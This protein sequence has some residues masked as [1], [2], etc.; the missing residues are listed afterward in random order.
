[1][2]QLLQGSEPAGGKLKKQEKV[3][4]GLQV[5]KPGR[6]PVQ[7]GERLPRPSGKGLWRRTKRRCWEAGR[8][9][10]GEVGLCPAEVGMKTG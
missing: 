7:A 5:G 2:R 1:M 9:S 6:D 8:Q 3:R 4:K 10:L